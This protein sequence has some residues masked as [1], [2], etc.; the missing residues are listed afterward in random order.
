MLIKG[1]LCLPT[2]AEYHHRPY[3]VELEKQLFSTRGYLPYKSARMKIN[4]FTFAH[5]AG[6]G[7]GAKT[8]N[9]PL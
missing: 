2:F 4:N 7:G 9:Y 6:K 3:D 5:V 8:Q 1:F